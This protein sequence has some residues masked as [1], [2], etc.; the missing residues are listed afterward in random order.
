MA[1]YTEYVYSHLCNLESPVPKP[2]HHL[3]LRGPTSTQKALYDCMEGY[4]Y[5]QGC[6]QKFCHGGRIWGMNK[7]GAG[8]GSSTVSCEAQGMLYGRENQGRESQFD[9]N[10]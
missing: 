3:C 6:M 4:V 8:D 9:T 5:C 7:K 2:Q 10:H 1:G